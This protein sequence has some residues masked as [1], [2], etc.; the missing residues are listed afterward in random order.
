MD[1]ETLNKYE[2]ELHPYK[3]AEIKKDLLREREKEIQNLLTEN[4]P[5]EAE[6]IIKEF[7]EGDYRKDEK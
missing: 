3:T 2:G 5:E 4:N 6:K 1:F 7:H